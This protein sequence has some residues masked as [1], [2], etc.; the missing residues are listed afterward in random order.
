[1]VGVWGLAMEGSRTDKGWI[2]KRAKDVTSQEDP[3]RT[4]EPLFLFV[5]FTLLALSAKAGASG[6]IFL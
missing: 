4:T 2:S 1:M 5:S 3:Q 6:N